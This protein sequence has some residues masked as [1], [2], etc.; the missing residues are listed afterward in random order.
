[1]SR[2]LIVRDDLRLTRPQLGDDAV[3]PGVQ[4]QDDELAKFEVVFLEDRFDG[5]RLADCR[6]RRGHASR[7]RTDRFERRRL[8]VAAI[9]QELELVERLGDV[10][11]PDGFRQHADRAGCARLPA[12]DLALLGGVHHDRDRGEL[13][14]RLD[15][16][17][18]LEPVHARHQVIHEDHVRAA[19]LEVFEGGFRGIG[20]VHEDPVA[21]E[22]A[23]EDDPCGLGIVD[24]QRS[25]ARHH[26]ALRPLRRSVAQAV[27]AGMWT[28]VNF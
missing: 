28:S 17:N 25:L 21:L 10:D 7:G 6:R 19:V 16:A 23:R 1:M 14:L 3:R 27:R 9:G 22:H 4:C 2:I 20:R 24:D 18:G 5:R 26:S 15:L 11:R 8:F 13:G 12:V